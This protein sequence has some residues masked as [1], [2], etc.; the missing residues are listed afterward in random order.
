VFR[1][2]CAVC[3]FPEMKMRVAAKVA[4]GVQLSGRVIATRVSQAG[5]VGRILKG[6]GSLPLL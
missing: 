1:K 5:I 4:L 6:L 2:I 3:G